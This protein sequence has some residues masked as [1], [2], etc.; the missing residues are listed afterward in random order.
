MKSRFRTLLLVVGVLLLLSAIFYAR[1]LAALGAYLVQT[2]PL[3]KADVAL[4]LAGDGW[5]HRILT[6]A[7][8]ERDGYVPKVI[9]SGTDGAGSPCI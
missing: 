9:V 8:L 7:Q 6:A 4:V 2:D 1:I 5:G 3:Q